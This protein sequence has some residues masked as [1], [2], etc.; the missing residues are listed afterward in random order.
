VNLDQ[1]V[2]RALRLLDGGLQAKIA[3]NPLTVLRND[4]GL[5]VEA[6]D[7]LV[8]RRDDGGACDGM[9]FLQDGVIL[10]ASTP[11]SR[12][13]NFT[14][15]HEL[16]HWLVEQ[17]DELYGWLAD[18]DDPP[19]MLETVCDRVGQRLLLPDE[20]VDSVVA[21]GPIRARHVLELYSASRASVP[22]CSIALA[23]RLPHLGAVAIVDQDGD[24][25]WRAACGWMRIRGACAAC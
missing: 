25:S 18:Q 14:L 20:M 11:H 16:G 24:G 4:L 5:Q 6:V 17:V 12:R 22:A 10:Y 8:R 3:V 19:R 21:G 13:E 2:D 7:H 9:S 23:N 1:C 15:T